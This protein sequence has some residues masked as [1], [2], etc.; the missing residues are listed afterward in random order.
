[1]SYGTVV[2]ELAQSLGRQIIAYDNL[3]DHGGCILY[4]GGPVRRIDI[5]TAALEEGSSDLAAFVRQVLSSP[6]DDQTRMG[7]GVCDG[8]LALLAEPVPV[9][10][11]TM[12]AVADLG[13]G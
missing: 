11:T 4:V 7:I 2:K 8:K 3:P 13:E 1:M 6:P 12:Q 5:T 10:D 9:K